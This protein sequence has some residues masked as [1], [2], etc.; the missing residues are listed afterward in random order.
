MPLTR[1]TKQWK[2]G[3][4]PRMRNSG[5]VPKDHACAPGPPAGPGSFF[6]TVENFTVF[7]WCAAKRGTK[8]AEKDQSRA[9]RM[10][11][12][13]GPQTGDDPWDPHRPG[14]QTACRQVMWYTP[15]S[16]AQRDQWAAGPRKGASVMPGKGCSETAKSG[17]T[18]PIPTPKP[19]RLRSSWA[20]GMPWRRSPNRAQS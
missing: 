15:G 5:G 10:H 1:L 4:L 13:C 2:Y 17:H 6:V 18:I 19:K 8:D 12:K 9:L 14:A 7:P 16:D 20:V 11:G 3:D